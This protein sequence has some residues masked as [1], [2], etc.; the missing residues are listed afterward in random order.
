MIPFFKFKSFDQQKQ[1]V[2]E[3]RKCLWAIVKV[4]ITC[5]QRIQ[6]CQLGF[7][8]FEDLAFF[9]LF[10]AKFGIFPFLDLATLKGSSP[11]R[12]YNFWCQIKIKVEKFSNKFMILVDGRVYSLAGGFYMSISIFFLICNWQS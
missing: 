12:E 2:Y 10:M 5:L 7:F 8:I 1:E 3:W 9:E 6:C 11:G 4:V